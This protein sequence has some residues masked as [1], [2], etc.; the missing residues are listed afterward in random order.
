MPLL[1]VGGVAFSFDYLAQ[2]AGAFSI[3]QVDL[4]IQVVL[5]GSLIISLYVVLRHLTLQRR[6]RAVTLHLLQG[7]Q[8]FNQTRDALI[9]QT[10]R[11]LNSL[12]AGFDTHVAAL[13]SSSVAELLKEGQQ[14]LHDVV[15][16][17]VIAQNLKGAVANT[18]PT[19]IQLRAVCAPA[20]KALEDKAQAKA[21]TVTILQDLALQV[22]SPELLNL[23][24]Q[25]VLDNAIAYSH[26]KGHV[27]IAASQTADTFTIA[28]TD[29]GPGIPADKQALLFQ[30]FSK[31]EGAE[32]FNHEGMGFNL[33]L[34]KLIMAYLLGTIRVE[35]V[36]PQGTQVLLIL[37]RP[38]NSVV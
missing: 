10:A 33:Y 9:D 1:L 3:S 13:A 5:F 4:V 2:H 17:F 15:G 19:T 26:D 8:S 36:Q 24:I 25:T 29:H 12:L 27:E 37:P 7:E 16:R 22:R 35:S 30:A 32:V 31:L 6:D 21:V 23:A 20:I 14:R 18:T 34:D 28:I 38:G 11:Q